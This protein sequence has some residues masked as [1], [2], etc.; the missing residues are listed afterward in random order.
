[1]ANFLGCLFILIFSLIFG[2]F[3]AAWGFL[4]TGFKIFF[5]NKSFGQQQNKQH[6]NSANHSQRPH[7][8]YSAGDAHHEG[9]RP[10]SRQRRSGKIFEKNEREYIDFEE[11]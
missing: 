5:G 7:T 2:L 1:M 10:N 9:T 11:V 3:I 8:S 4:R 6:Y